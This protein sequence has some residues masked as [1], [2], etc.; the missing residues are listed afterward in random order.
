MTREAM[1]EAR[2]G[3][4]NPIGGLDEQTTRAMFCNNK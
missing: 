1:E 3:G 4:D 2:Q